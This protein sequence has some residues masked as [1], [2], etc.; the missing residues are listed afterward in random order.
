M[1]NLKI[2]LL[3]MPFL[4]GSC[5][6]FLDLSPEFQLNDKLF[7]RTVQDF[8]TAS[9]GNYSQ[10]QVI[11]NASILNLTELTTDNAEV[12]W[13]SPETS[14]AEC[15]E[16]NLTSNNTFVNT[17]WNS[18]F[19]TISR[20][21]T[22]INKLKESTLNN[23]EKM[24]YN[25]E[26]RFLRAFCYFNLVRL[27][28]DLPLVLDNF[29]G[30]VS[31]NA[32]DMSRKPSEE[33]YKLIISDLL[34]AVTELE[35]VKAT[36]S[37]A[38]VGSA[39][40]LLAKV[41]LTRR[42]FEKAAPLL[43]SLIESKS[44]D[45]QA[46]YKSL[47]ST[48]NENLKES[49]FEIEYLSGNIGEGNSYSTLFTPP[50]FNMAI[51]PGNMAG[52]G[53]IVA[54]KEIKNSYEINDARKSGSIM[55]SLKLRTGLFEKTHY[56]LKFVDFSTGLAGDGGVNFTVFRY[57]DVLLMYSEV[58]NESGKFSNALTYLNLVR[59]RAKLADI[60]ST[61]QSEIRLILEKERRIEFLSEGHRWF[62]LVRTGRALVV[63]NDYFAQQ[64]LKFTI[65][66]TELL[67]P[68]PQREIDIN[69]S[70]LQNPGY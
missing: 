61:S 59:K 43:S 31:I 19:K 17:V 22:I 62:D 47:F 57:A 63:L 7:Y 37:R 20:S 11:Y 52:S 44:Y 12:T 33:I 41:Y 55:D 25:G 69:P 29:T 26:A 60:S 5:T 46:D 21:N 23:A 50:S 3:L 27:F 36:K 40:T 30:P 15:D 16:I 1:K 70:L 56:G 39:K 13:T 45:L 54:S 28:G 35:G 67:M 58:L 2:A 38:S 8:E 9:I 10:L 18:S 34:Q 64:K 66:S 68:I 49:I 24:R 4:S 42:E 32:F 53:R 6:D 14:E 65:N 48:G 51:F